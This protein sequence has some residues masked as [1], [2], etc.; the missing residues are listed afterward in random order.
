[1]LYFKFIILDISSLKLVKKFLEKTCSKI[2]LGCFWILIWKTSNFFLTITQVDQNSIRLD[3]ARLID[4]RIYCLVERVEQNI[5]NGMEF[6]LRNQKHHLLLASGALRTADS[7]GDHFTSRDWTENMYNLTRPGIVRPANSRRTLVS[8]HGALMVSFW[9][10]WAFIF[11]VEK[12]KSF[13]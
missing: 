6:D 1:M 13:N 10:L 7:I 4:G 11:Y 3:T 12:R 8:V 5:I 9:L 2:W